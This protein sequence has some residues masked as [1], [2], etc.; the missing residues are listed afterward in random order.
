MMERMSGGAR[1]RMSKGADEQGS[2]GADSHLLPC[3]PAH[4]P[5]RS[6]AQLEWESL[7]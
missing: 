5:T 1:E 3:P 7:C 4:L 2:G 6:S